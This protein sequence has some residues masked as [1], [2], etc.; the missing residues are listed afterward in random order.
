[1]IPFRQV[2]IIF[3]ILGGMLA[4]VSVPDF[5]ERNFLLLDNPSLSTLFADCKPRIAIFPS[6][7]ISE[8]RTI[9]S[10]DRPLFHDLESHLHL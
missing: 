8:A 4:F 3:S 9:E 10:I 1:M 5:G 7:S 6:L 2:G